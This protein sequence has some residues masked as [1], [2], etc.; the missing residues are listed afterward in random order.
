[1]N[2]TVK[3]QIYPEKSQYL[4]LDLFLEMIVQN[5]CHTVTKTHKVTIIRHE[6]GTDM[7]NN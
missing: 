5:D 7:Q 3:K 2:N 1:M 6:K 4:S